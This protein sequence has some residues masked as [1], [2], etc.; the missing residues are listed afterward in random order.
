MYVNGPDN[1]SGDRNAVI[2]TCRPASMGEFVMS[3]LREGGGGATVRAKCGGV[4]PALTALSRKCR[5]LSS[6]KF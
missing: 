6:Y 3:A 5:S 4:V 1:A 2:T